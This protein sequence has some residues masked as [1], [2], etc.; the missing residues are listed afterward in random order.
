M[1]S[2]G[3]EQTSFPR[4]IQTNGLS[5]PASYD[6]LVAAGLLTSKPDT[7]MVKQLFGN[8][9]Q[10]VPVKIFDLTAEGKSQLQTCFRPKKGCL[11]PSQDS[12]R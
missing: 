11:A 1:V 12:V 7:A 9:S 6:A 3:L 8:A 2:V 10:S 4:T 5:D